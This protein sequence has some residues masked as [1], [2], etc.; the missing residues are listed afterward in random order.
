MRRGAAGFSKE[1]EET[2]SERI[3]MEM[4]RGLGGAGGWD[5]AGSSAVFEPDSGARW[6]TALTGGAGRSAAE[7]EA[8]A[9]AGGEEEAGRP[10]GLLGCGRGRRRERWAGAERKEGPRGWAPACGQPSERERG[11]GVK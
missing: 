6:T 1:R 9:R 3:R 8:A 11:R 7:E 4:R 10:A 2:D 5:S